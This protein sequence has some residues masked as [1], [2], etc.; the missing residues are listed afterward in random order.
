MELTF[1]ELLALA[2]TV[3]GII[4]IAV[5]FSDQIARLLYYLAWR[6]RQAGGSK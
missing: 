2:I 3:Y 1:D 6:Q 4:A 5:I